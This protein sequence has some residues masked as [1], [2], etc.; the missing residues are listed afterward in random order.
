MTR[1]PSASPRRRRPR[2]RGR[3]RHPGCRRR[4]PSRHHA[5]ARSAG[6][7]ASVAPAV[8]RSPARPGVRFHTVTGRPA[9]RRLV[10]MCRPIVPRP[11]NPTRSTPSSVLVRCAA[12]H[13]PRHGRAHPDPGTRPRRRPAGTTDRLAAR[14]DQARRRREA[15]WSSAREDAHRPPGRSLGC[16]HARRHGGPLQGLVLASAAAARRGAPRASVSNLELLYDLVYVAVIGQASHALAAHL[17]AAG[18]S[19]SRSCSG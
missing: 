12:H 9:A 10:A 17:G 5:R 18:S 4:R 1:P 7:A 15:G 16:R 2:R 6:V 3:L 14:R 13:R 19:S 8:T 11:T